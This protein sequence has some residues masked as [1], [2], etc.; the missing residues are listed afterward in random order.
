MP[1]DTV[2]RFLKALSPQHRETVEQQPRERQE[3]LAA[4]WETELVQD[5]DLDTLSEL[6]PPAAE[7]EAALRVFER[8]TP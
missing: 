1:D 3:R 5:T 8:H 2:T 6:S 7:S 4:E